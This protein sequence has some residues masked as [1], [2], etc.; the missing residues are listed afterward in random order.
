M[1]RDP[2]DR[3]FKESAMSKKKG[4][5]RQQPKRSPDSRAQFI[6]PKKASAALL[7]LCVVAVG[8]AAVSWQPVRRAVGLAPLYE[9]SAQ[10]TPTPL[11]LSK[12]YVY[13]GGRLV[14]TE[15]PGPAGPPPANL[16]ATATTATR[17]E[18]TWAAP[19]SGSVTA[20]VIESA[21]KDTPFHQIGT[22]AAGQLSFVDQ[23]AIAGQSFLY[24]VK[25]TFATGG[26]SGYSN[27]DLATTVI[28]SGD[29]PLIGANDPQGRTAST[30]R[31]ANLTELRTAI[32]AV[33]ELAGI[34]AGTWKNDPAPL[35]NGAIL[36][37]HFLELRTNLNPALAA[38]GLTTLPDDS[39][40]AAGLPVR[41]AHIQNVRDKVK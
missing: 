19:S 33:R 25:A 18:L 27:N 11:S 29:D 10:A 13:A 14:A 8:W 34:G 21:S 31:A 16:V 2:R 32:V 40:L 6:L 9:P 36:K 35:S 41:A 37:D 24:R 3:S 30:V 12:E 39:T 7:V 5:K 23:P 22:A 4:L 26:S 1:R 15:E 20:Y 28:F 17:V 38:L